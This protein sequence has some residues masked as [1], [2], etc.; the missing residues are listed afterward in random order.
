MIKPSLLKAHI[1]CSKVGDSVMSKHSLREV[2]LPTHTIAGDVL[3]ILEDEDIFL[4]GDL[5]KPEGEWHSTPQLTFVEVEVLPSPDSD[6]TIMIA[7]TV[8]MKETDVSG[9]IKKVCAFC[10]IS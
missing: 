8:H 4:P 7:F 3:E 10:A 5:F 2:N 1:E 6:Y 9:L